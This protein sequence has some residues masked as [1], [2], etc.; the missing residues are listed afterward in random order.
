MR[1]RGPDPLEVVVIWRVL[2]GQHLVEA[3]IIFLLEN[4]CILSGV[5]AVR[6]VLAVFR[7]LIDEE[8]LS[9]LMPFENKCCSFSKCAFTASRIWMRCK[10]GFIDVSQ[11]LPG[12]QHEA[13]G[14]HHDLIVRIDLGND[15]ALAILF[16]VSRK[17][18]QVIALAEDFL[19]ALDA[20]ALH[21]LE[22]DHRFR[23]FG[24]RDPDRRRNSSH[25]ISAGLGNNPRPTSQ[26]LP[27][28][29]GA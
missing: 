13:A 23:R 22:L 19:H 2:D 4:P 1:D 21:H 7:H 6:R 25:W 14:E 12:A 28:R 18:V 15:I 24:R 17:R 3:Q 20:G 10:Q 27:D 11:R 9:T 29:P 26:R 16:K 8:Q 5:V